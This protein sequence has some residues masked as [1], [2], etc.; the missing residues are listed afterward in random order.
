MRYSWNYQISR[1]VHD[2]YNM[3]VTPQMRHFQQKV[4]PH[5]F[6]NYARHW[7]RLSLSN[8]GELL[9]KMA[10]LWSSLANP[11]TNGCRTPLGV[12][13]VLRTPSCLIHSISDGF[14]SPSSIFSAIYLLAQSICFT[15]QYAGSCH[16]QLRKAGVILWAWI[17]QKTDVIYSSIDVGQ[18]HRLLRL[19][20]LLDLSMKVEEKR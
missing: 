4:I 18:L 19:R 1:I 16:C 17:I 6:S 2:V 13:G 15:R 14:T 8:Y 20:Q 7:R 9:G 10:A 3:V 5:T 11:P 12:H